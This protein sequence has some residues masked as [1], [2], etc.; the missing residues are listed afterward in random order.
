MTSLNPSSCNL[1]TFTGVMLMDTLLSQQ[2]ADLL[3]QA[4]L[5]EH[6]SLQHH[7][8]LQHHASSQPHASLQQHTGLQ[9]VVFLLQKEVTRPRARFKP[10]LPQKSEV[11][12]GTIICQ[13]R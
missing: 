8:G 2:H 12:G 9:D 13:H 10:T 3:H 4:S 6:A 11:D 1:V 5:Q 7:A